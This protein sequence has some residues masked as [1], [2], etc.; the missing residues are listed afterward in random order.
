MSVMSIAKPL[1][2]ALFTHSGSRF[3]R[4]V[5]FGS[6]REASF[7]PSRRPTPQGFGAFAGVPKCA[8]S[9]ETTPWT[10]TGVSLPLS[11]R[12]VPTPDAGPQ[13][14]SAPTLAECKRPQPTNS[15]GQPARG[16]EPSASSIPCSA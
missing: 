11:R 9:D 5:A 6:A 1:A 13:H 2:F 14:R 16:G 4:R 12:G 8:K 15:K 10:R 3:D 7:G